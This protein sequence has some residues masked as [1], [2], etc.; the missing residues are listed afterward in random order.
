L[1]QIKPRPVCT[2]SRWHL[3]APAGDVCCLKS[4]KGARGRCPG[5]AWNDF[6]PR[7]SIRRPSIRSACIIP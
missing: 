6:T 4:P 5:P 2:P 3:D 7:S 1:C